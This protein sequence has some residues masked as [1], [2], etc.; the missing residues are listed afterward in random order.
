MEG[1][2]KTLGKLDEYSLARPKPRG[3]STTVNNYVEVGEVLLSAAKF[4]PEYVERAAGLI[5]GKGYV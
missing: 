3:P 5:N 2:L 1:Y 4:M